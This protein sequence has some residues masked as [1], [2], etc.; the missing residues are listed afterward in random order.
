MACVTALIEWHRR[1]QSG[2]CVTR[3]GLYSLV[4]RIKVPKEDRLSGIVGENRHAGAGC[5]KYGGVHTVNCVAQGKLYKAWRRLCWGLCYPRPVVQR[6]DA[7][8]CGSGRV[9][10]VI[11]YI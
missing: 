3:G 7:S 10:I 6:M 11:F 1:V 9:I 8:I 5:T 4:F 2:D